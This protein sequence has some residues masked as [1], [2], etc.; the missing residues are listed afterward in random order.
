MRCGVVGPG[1]WAEWERPGGEGGKVKIRR[2]ELGSL[3]VMDSKDVCDFD[4][5]TEANF[6]IFL[7]F[8]FVRTSAGARR[9]TTGV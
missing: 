6:W 4:A 5:S 3:R 8:F 1:G 7:N 2:V 9:M